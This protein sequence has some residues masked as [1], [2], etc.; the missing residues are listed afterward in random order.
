MSPNL[1]VAEPFQPTDT[2]VAA[3]REA[4]RALMHLTEQD[5]PVQVQAV[6][7]AGGLGETA[8][9]PQAAVRLLI[10]ILG[11]IAD[12]NAVSIVPVHAELTTQQAADL[13]NVSRPFMVGL[14][15]KG[16]L[17]FHK[18]GTH[19]RVRF[20]DLIAYKRREHEARHQA[21]DEL[22]RQGQDLGLGY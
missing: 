14:L 20:G 6:E 21:L 8:L 12:G 7:A 19:R 22:A 1:A 4:K 10:D 5:R 9:L 16:E 11:Q 18:V 17:P 3:A 13:L 2:D 15:E